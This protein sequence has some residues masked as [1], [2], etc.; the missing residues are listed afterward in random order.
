M[1]LR[2]SAR[3]FF[4]RNLDCPRQLFCEPL[5]QLL[6]KYVRFTTRQTET[7]RAI[8][9]ALGGE[10]G[11]RLAGKLNIPMSPDTLLRRIKQNRDSSPP[12]PRI[13]GV[14]DWAQLFQSLPSGDELGTNS[15]FRDN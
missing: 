12:T 5:P 3:R 13:V 10:P 2:L 9:L 8:G 4:C 11:S 15:V 1:V 6:A 14:D 7:H